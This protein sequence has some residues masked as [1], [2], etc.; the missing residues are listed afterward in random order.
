M[1]GAHQRSVTTVFL[2][3]ISFDQSSK[4][5]VCA[6]TKS[7]QVHGITKCISFEAGNIGLNILYA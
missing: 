7:I 3:R 2:I 6:I 4:L 1:L 5:D